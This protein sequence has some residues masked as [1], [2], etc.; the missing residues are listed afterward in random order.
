MFVKFL[1]R[2]ILVLSAVYLAS[3]QAHTGVGLNIKIPII[4]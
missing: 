2:R 4:E 1:N 3:H